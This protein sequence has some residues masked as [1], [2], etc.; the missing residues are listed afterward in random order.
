MSNKLVKNEEQKEG[1]T[2][3]QKKIVFW[4]SLLILSMAFVFV[5]GKVLMTTKAFNEQ[6]KGLKPVLLMM[7]YLRTISSTTRT[8][9]PGSIINGCRYRGRYIRNM[10]WEIA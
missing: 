5:W 8:E 9:K 7:Q 3:K 1:I 6:I 2:G 4:G 10:L